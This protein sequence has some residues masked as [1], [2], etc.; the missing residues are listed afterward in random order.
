MIGVDIGELLQC[1]CDSF[2]EEGHESE[3]E[4]MFFNKLILVTLS[5]CDDSAHISLIERGEHGCFIFHCNKS[6]TNLFPELAHP[7]ALFFPSSTDF[8]KSLAS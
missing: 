2:G 6:L 1:Q 5:Q 8:F 3:L 7:V 4:A